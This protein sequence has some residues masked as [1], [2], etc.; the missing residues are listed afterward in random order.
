MEYKTVK[1]REELHRKLKARAAENG[2]K[3]Q[4]FIEDILREKLKGGE[5][6]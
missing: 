1:I 2:E 3:L 4:D 5:T 6:K